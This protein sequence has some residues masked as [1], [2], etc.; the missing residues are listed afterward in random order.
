MTTLRGRLAKIEERLSTEVEIDQ[1]L[2]RRLWDVPHP[3]AIAAVGDWLDGDG[4][5]VEGLL[6]IN[7][8]HEYGMPRKTTAEAESEL[9]AARKL[10]ADLR[11][12]RMAGKPWHDILIT[13]PRDVFLCF[14]A[15]RDEQERLEA[16]T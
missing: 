10:A 16:A 12:G 13:M 7:R 14:C 8:R 5:S 3:D 11:A 6:A 9:D 1:E 15:Y 2:G 4:V